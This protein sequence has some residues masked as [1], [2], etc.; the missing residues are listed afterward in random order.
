MS[1]LSFDAMGFV[2]ALLSTAL[3]AVQNLY[4]KKAL[5]QVGIHHLALLSVLSKFAWCLL[6]PFWFLL[7]GAQIDVSREV[8]H[9]RSV[10][11]PLAHAIHCS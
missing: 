1:E 11:L 7:D 10:P 2:S 4:S 8:L 3:L 9:Q 5:T 6:V